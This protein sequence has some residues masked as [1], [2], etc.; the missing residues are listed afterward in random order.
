MIA[1]DNG[2]RRLEIVE[3]A[4]TYRIVGLR[5]SSGAEITVDQAAVDRVAADREA[6]AQ[7]VRDYQQGDRSQPFSFTPAP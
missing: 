6:Y 1:F 5:S 4:G 3:E 7:A 2:R